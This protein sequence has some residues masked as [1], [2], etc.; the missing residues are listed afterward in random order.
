MSSSS[1]SPSASPNQVRYVWSFS[2]PCRR[3]ATSVHR[4]SALS[5]K[6][7][8]TR[9][10]NSF[11]PARRGA[12]LPMGCPPHKRPSGENR[13]PQKRTFAGNSEL[14]TG[15]STMW[16]VLRIARIMRTLGCGFP[17]AGE[18]ANASFAMRIRVSEEGAP[19]FSILAR[20]RPRPSR[21]KPIIPPQRGSFP[22]RREANL[23]AER[24][25]TQAQARVPCA[26]EDPRRSRH[27]QAAPGAGTQ[28]PVG[29]VRDRS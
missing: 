21:P 15:V 14:S 8:S 13:T 12:S 3:R 9:P 29:L 5:S 10:S 23:S 4:V 27:P 19:T 26:H 2:D 24:A 18:F 11:R 22:E 20:R 28:A 17:Q 7:C 6:G 16:T 25:P 1:A